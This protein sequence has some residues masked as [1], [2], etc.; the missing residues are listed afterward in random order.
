MLAYEAS[1]VNKRRS[2]KKVIW[3]VIPVWIAFGVEA[4]GGWRFSK[5]DYSLSYA[6][7]LPDFATQ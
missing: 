2:L 1:E 4:L 7:D 5:D 3:L 6:I